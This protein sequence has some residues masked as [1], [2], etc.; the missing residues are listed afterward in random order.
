MLT[1]FIICLC[2]HLSII[3]LIICTAIMLFTY[4][5]IWKSILLLN[6]IC[7]FCNGLFSISN[8]QYETDAW[9]IFIRDDYY[10]YL[11][12]AFIELLYNLERHWTT[13][14]VRCF[15]PVCDR[16]QCNFGGGIHSK[17]CF[18]NDTKHEERN[19]YKYVVKCWNRSR[20]SVY[21]TI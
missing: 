18:Q 14:S 21:N 15:V 10:I 4:I 8:K 17:K 16:S 12:F 1:V 20:R 11:H 19:S 5:N 13:S 3:S 6:K 9:S 2:T 7:F